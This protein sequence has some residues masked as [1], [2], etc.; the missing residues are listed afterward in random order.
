MARVAAHAARGL[1]QLAHFAQE[2]LDGPAT[3]NR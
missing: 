3:A 1:S 2:T